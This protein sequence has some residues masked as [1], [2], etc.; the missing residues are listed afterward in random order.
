MRGV[1]QRRFPRTLTP[2]A[3][4]LL[5]LGLTGC[6]GSDS[7]SGSGSSA[8]AAGV[9]DPLFATLGNGGY[10]VRHYT[11]TL[12]Y[13]PGSRRLE[14]TADIVARAT[15]DLGSFHLDLH[16]LTVHEV[17]VDGDR[18]DTDRSGD[19]LIVRPAE[20]TADGATFRT[21]VRYSGVPRTITDPDGS[22]EGWLPTA[23]GALAVGEPA[24]SMAWFPSNNHPSDK[25]TYDIA[26][27]VPR[28]LQA[29]SNGTLA[30]ETTTATRTTTVWKS[31]Q[32]TASYL[33]TLAI[34]RYDV[35]RGTLPTGQQI[36]SAVDPTITTERRRLLAR[37]PEITRWSAERF[38]PYPFSA[39]GA[40]VVPPGEVGYA[41]ET[42][43]RPVFPADQFD[44]PTLVHEIAHQWYGNSVTPKTWKDMWLNEGF[45]T[46]AEWLWAEDFDGTPARE[47]FDAAFADEDNWAFPPAEPPSAA[48]ISDAPV[49]GR[50]A[51]VLHRV[52]TAVG[53]RTFRS[54]LAG[55]P[56]EYRHRNA[57]T[58]DFTAYV[59]N[60]SGTDL[61][62]VWKTWLYGT[63]KPLGP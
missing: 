30:R 19:E 25:A 60:V 45:A 52:R 15:Q 46:Y 51:M 14:G 56:R 61:D 59:E 58:A 21:V 40:I 23:D 1:D 48:R 38:G 7:G 44:L 47:S 57:S 18:A 17:T 13:D 28:G 35:T 16:G 42:Q 6:S 12:A 9:R 43:T 5:L 29:I 2:A 24:G 20:A 55:W 34:G 26:V 62:E 36:L 63:E 50:G 49:Y 4:L 53:E 37:I 39:G 3:A 11:L 32:P 22:E 41:L 33:V 10:D 54:I 27:T 31:E 8:G